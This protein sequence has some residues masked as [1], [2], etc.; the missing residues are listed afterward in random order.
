MTS[1]Y[2]TDPTLVTTADD[3][4]RIHRTMATQV[5]RINANKTLNDHARRVYIARAY[6]TAR[7]QATALREKAEQQ[8]RDRQTRL[9]KQLYGAA[10]SNDPGAVLAR[11]DAHERAAQLDDPREAS[12][13]LKRAERDGDTSMAQAI[14]AR[15][16]EWGWADL[17]NEYAATRPNW[18][19][20]MR[21]LQELPDVDSGPAKL[22]AAI[23]YGVPQPSELNGLPEYSVNSLAATDLGDQQ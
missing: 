16:V 4:A 3:V 15:A 14:A 17:I 18:A 13:A 23:T 5:E 8:V 19:G 10:G 20:N 12:A 2:D 1:Q 21:A 7:D 11:R 22:R 6:A 9:E